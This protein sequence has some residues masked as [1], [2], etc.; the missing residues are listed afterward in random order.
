MSIEMNP[1]EFGIVYR[2]LKEYAELQEERTVA[3]SGDDA[4]ES[5][6]EA[7]EA[8]ELY[9]QINNLN[10]AGDR[11]HYEIRWVYND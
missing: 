2:A 8:R 11:G 6:K 5:Q 10:H 9:A 1:W 3:L 7:R 4:R